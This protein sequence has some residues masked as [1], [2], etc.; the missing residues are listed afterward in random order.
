MYY[1]IIIAFLVMALGIFFFIRHKHLKP[2]FSF[3]T[4]MELVELPIITLY[5]KNK[6]LH[7]ILDTGC[8]NSVI[9]STILPELQYSESEN[10]MHIFGIEGKTQESSAIILDFTYE[11]TFYTHTFQAINLSPSFKQIKKIHGIT[12]HGLLGTDFFNKYKYI[13]DF[14]KLIAYSKK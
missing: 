4:A 1:L 11:N 3:K 9:D 8:N 5:H 13:I 12:V 14:D 2:I 7:F 10:S 6:K